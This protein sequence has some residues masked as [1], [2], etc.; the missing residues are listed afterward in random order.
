MCF[1]RWI[2]ICEFGRMLHFFFGNLRDFGAGRFCLVCFGWST[3]MRNTGLPV[4][5]A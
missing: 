4:S 1:R 3:Y 2:C 5:P